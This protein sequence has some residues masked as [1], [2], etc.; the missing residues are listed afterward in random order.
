MPLSCP[1]TDYIADGLRHRKWA[2][3][4]RR[5]PDGGVRGERWVYAVGVL[6]YVVTFTVATGRYLDAADTEAP[7]AL[8]QSYHRP[9][10]G[11]TYPCIYLD[12]VPCRNDGSGIDAFGW[13]ADQ[14]KDAAG[15]VPDAAVF[16]H[17][18][19]LYALWNGE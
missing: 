2:W 9:E 5:E 8:E 15:V 17:L 16:A 6:P 13:Y 12:G 14:P 18:R 7:W 3:P 1:D 4:A 11:G 19:E 10:T